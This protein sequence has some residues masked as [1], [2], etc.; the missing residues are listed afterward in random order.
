MNKNRMTV[1][2]MKELLKAN[3]NGVE[4]VCDDGEYLVTRGEIKVTAINDNYFLFVDSEGW[5]NYN[6][7]KNLRHYPSQKPEKTIYYKWVMQESYGHL[8]EGMDF[9]SK[10]K[11]YTDGRVYIGSAEL[12]RII[13]GTGIYADGSKAVEGE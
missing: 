2:E 12:I 4:L 9:I 10:D 5:N 1:E 8:Y 11:G 6:H 3:P 7:G 13:E